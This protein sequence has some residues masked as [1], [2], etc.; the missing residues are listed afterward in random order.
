MNEKYIGNEGFEINYIYNKLI[1]ILQVPISSINFIQST[2]H[3]NV[4]NRP[5]QQIKTSIVHSR[6][7]AL[8]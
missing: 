2:T 1:Q 4:L 6:A 8:L 3:I 5:L 7:T